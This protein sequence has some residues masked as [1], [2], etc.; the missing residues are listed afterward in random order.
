MVQAML[1]VILSQPFLMSSLFK[2]IALGNQHVWTEP[3][4]AST[5]AL[6]ELRGHVG[7]VRRFFR[8]F[9]FLESFRT[10]HLIYTSFYAP[11][12]PP[13]PPL[14]PATVPSPEPATKSEVLNGETRPNATEALHAEAS[15]PAQ[16]PT[17]TPTHHHRPQNPTKPPAEAWLDIFSRTFNGMY[18]LLETLTLLDAL[19]LPGLSLWGPAWSSLLN[20]EGQRFWFLSLACG[21]LGGLVKLAKLVAYAPAP[22]TAGGEAH[23]G[24]GEGQGDPMPE[25][26]RQRE[27][28]RRLVYARRESRRAWRE[29]IRTRG[30]GLARRCVADFLDLA[31]PGSVLGWVGVEP[32][33]V[34]VVMVVSTWLTGREVWERCAREIGRM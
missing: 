32:G 27:K 30:Y 5:A 13:P 10:A 19:K 3:R 28:M 8:M 15:P 34:G 25:W 6:S 12:P 26:K 17:P 4:I 7:L 24:A 23:G 11:P 29:Q 22:Q 14:I 9:R 20:I 21:V 33:T 16:S 18:L 31:V 2:L 1:M